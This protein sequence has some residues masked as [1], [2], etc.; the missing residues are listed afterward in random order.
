VAFVA[1][2]AFAYV[3][4]DR[5]RNLEVKIIILKVESRARICKS[6]W[7][8]GIDSKES[9]PPS[10]VVWW[11][12]LRVRHIELSYRPARQGIDSWAP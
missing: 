11:S 8:P 9:I 10:Y 12:G 6:L 3:L 1:F 4:P 7:S 2:V 5:N